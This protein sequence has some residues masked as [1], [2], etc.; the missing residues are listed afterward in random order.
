M[1]IRAYSSSLGYLGLSSYNQT[2]S[3]YPAQ[4][5]NPSSIQILYP[6]RLSIYDTFVFSWSGFFLKNPNNLNQSDFKKRKKK[7]KPFLFLIQ[8]TLKKV[9]QS[10]GTYLW[11][12]S[13]KSADQALLKKKSKT[14]GKPKQSVVLI[15]YTCQLFL[16][17]ELNNLSCAHNY[18]HRTP[19]YQDFPLDC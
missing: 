6:V 12:K 2:L 3:I 18:S 5:W 10:P 17:I 13:S 7:P 8:Y 16:F 1:K 11:R 14:N 4:N 9:E 15:Q 19:L